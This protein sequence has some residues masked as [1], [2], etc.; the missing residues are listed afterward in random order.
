MIIKKKTRSIKK[1]KK[2]CAPWRGSVS[3]CFARGDLF[4]E[5]LV[6]E[7]AENAEPSETPWH[8]CDGTPRTA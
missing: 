4:V 5:S 2:K 6:R 7:S 8:A 3:A 1:K